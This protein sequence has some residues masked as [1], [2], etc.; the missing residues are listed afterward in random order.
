MMTQRHN[1]E[2]KLYQLLAENLI[3]YKAYTIEERTF[4]YKEK[5]YTSIQHF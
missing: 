2:Y 5:Y 3:H 1:K 4:L